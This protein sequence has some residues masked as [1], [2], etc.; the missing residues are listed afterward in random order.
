MNF[1]E[2]LEFT[3]QARWLFK[4]GITQ[5]IV[6]FLYDHQLIQYT[7][8]N[9]SETLELD[10]EEVDKAIKWLYDNKNLERIP[11]NLEGR[12]RSIKEAMQTSAYKLTDQSVALYTAFE[13]IS[14]L[15]T[16]IR[17]S[18]EVNDAIKFMQ[19]TDT[20]NETLTKLAHD[21]NNGQLKQKLFEGKTTLFD[22][23][24]GFDNGIYR[25][26]KDR[27]N[28]FST[29]INQMQL[30]V[31][32]T[33]SENP[34]IF[35][36]LNILLIRLT[37]TIKEIMEQVKDA[38]PEIIA[39]IK[40]LAA[41]QKAIGASRFYQPLAQEILALNANRT[42]DEIC[43]TMFSTI[44]DIAH[45]E[46]GSNGLF[47]GLMGRLNLMFD[48]VIDIN[49]QN[50]NITRNVANTQKYLQLAHEFTDDMTPEELALRFDKLEGTPVIH[51]WVMS[52]HAR[53]DDND[54]RLHYD[55]QPKAR[56]KAVPKAARSMELSATE[57]ELLKQQQAQREA[58][59]V[60]QQ[61][62]GQ[63]ILEHGLKE[64]LPNDAYEWLMKLISESIFHYYFDQDGQI[65][66]GI[67]RTGAYQLIKTYQTK[68]MVIRSEAKTL[69]L[70]KQQ[71]EVKLNEDQ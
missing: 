54:E 51:H 42:A 45:D 43:A 14:K 44:E 35:A 34:E 12:A 22:I 40:R 47:A 48:M 6:S 60:R 61:Q 29:N 38:I 10:Y 62:L 37:N 56:K 64:T 32:Q 18:I 4:P 41:S 66:S 23:C 55:F 59:K 28:D 19:A 25:R 30:R 52:K 33:S 17:E 49:R 24:Y 50:R 71:L 26:F 13:Q 65:L 20:L 7:P 2:D 8:L 67:A 21:P 58:E 69:T 68:N 3:D 46:A 31:Y 27:I 57:K 15:E 39:S 36:D 70:F 1:Y 11:S 53:F 5:Q 63:Y 16:K 9:L